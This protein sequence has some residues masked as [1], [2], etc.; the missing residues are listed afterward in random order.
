MTKNWII[1]E[2][3]NE[4]DVKH[5]Q[6]ALGVV[7]PIANI[8]VQRGIKTYDQARAFFRPSLDDLHDPFLM[9]DMEKAVDRIEQAIDNQE[10]LLIYG[11]YDVDG[12]TAVSLVYSY[13]SQF[14][15]HTE[16][17]I[18]D[19]YK[20]GYGISKKGIDYAADNGHRL[21]IALDC[22][23][24]AVDKIEYARTKGVEFIICDHHT[25][26]DTIPDAVAVL[27]AKRKDCSYPYDELSGCG[28]GFK[29]IQA[30]QQKRGGDFNELI[31]YLDLVAISIASDIVPIT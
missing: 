13:F 25:P 21:I 29:L 28:V 6:E 16:Y 22:G 15:K 23:I 17:Y 27:D 2:Q 8:L 9:K 12:T 4:A 1:K 7:K 20:E 11:D 18:P 5:L 30:F 14:L 10:G 31:P 3:G 19:R 24:K 26:D